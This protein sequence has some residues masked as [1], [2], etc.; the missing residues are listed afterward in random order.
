MNLTTTQR[1]ALGDLLRSLATREQLTQDALAEAISI[2]RATISKV[3]RGE[4]KKSDHYATQAEYF[5]LTLHTALAHAE[6]LAGLLDAVVPGHSPASHDIHN[7]DDVELLPLPRTR[8]FGEQPLVIAVA[9]QKGGTGKTTCAVNLAHEFAQLGHAVLLVDLDPQG[10]AT[11]HV[12]GH[13]DAEHYVNAVRRLKREGLEAR[14]A[15]SLELQRTPFG[16]DLMPSGEDLE[17]AAERIASFA[18][19]TTVLRKLLAQLAPL[20]DVVFIDCQ[21]TLGVLQKN[22]IVAAS[23]LVF[24]VQLHQAAI[25]GLD[26]MMSTVDELRELNPTCKVLG[27]LPCFDENTVLAREMMRQLRQRYYARPTD[28]SIPKNIAI[29]EAYAAQEP[30]SAYQNHSAGAR[31]FQALA[32]E[33]VDRLALMELGESEQDDEEVS[34]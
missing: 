11:L 29:A 26:R 15:E 12:G 25:N 13:P 4:V 31:A 27:S 23:H 34:A 22:A 28:Q 32:V 2:D 6:H 1:L 9:S 10:D 18:V 21:P 33:L 14:P 16:F 5:G 24:P 20:Y 19:P 7:H 30:V 17:E 8:A 3:W